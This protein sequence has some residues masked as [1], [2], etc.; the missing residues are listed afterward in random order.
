MPLP[1]QLHH[2][3]QLVLPAF[4]VWVLSYELVARYASRL[5]AVDL[6]SA[7]DAQI[8]F[9]AQW[10]WIY[11]LTYVVPFLATLVV[12]DDE[13]VYRALVAVGLA[14]FTAYV[15]YVLYPVSSPRPV[16]GAGV[17]DQLVALQQRLD[18]PA[19]QLPSLHVA[20]AW[21]LYATVAGERRERW[22]RAA[23]AALAFAITLS[24]LF[25]KQHVLLDVLAGVLWGGAAYWASG[26]VYA[27]LRAI[28][29]PGRDGLRRLQ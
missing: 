22:L 16:P 11:V 26:S 24:T 21:I 9:R 15:V 18:Y 5:P 12:K 2:R 13:R 17:A 8:P 25:V 10:I 29:A 3:L 19:N 27:R 23:C 14:S 4:G 28:T 20:N 1:A 7:L 6:T